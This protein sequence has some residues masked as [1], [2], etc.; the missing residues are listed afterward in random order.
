MPP[1]LN[2]KVWWINI[3]TNNLGGD[4]CNVDAITVG[5]IRI[6]EEIRKQYAKTPIVLNSLLPRGKEELLRVNK[7][8]PVMQKINYNLECYAGTH[9]NLHFFNATAMFI[10]SFSGQD[11]GTEYF[12]NETLMHDYL[13][14]SGEGSLLW[15]QAIIEDLDKIIAKE[16]GG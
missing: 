16:E 3:G 7:F 10:D 11:Y 2:P 12:V 15:G 14:P 8:W 13:H 5:N 1:A 4:N 9:D 6:V